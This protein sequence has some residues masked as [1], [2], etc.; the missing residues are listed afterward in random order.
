MLYLVIPQMSPEAAQSPVWQSLTTVSPSRSMLLVYTTHCTLIKY[1]VL[2]SF[3]VLQWY[4]IE[5]LDHRTHFRKII[6]SAALITSPECPHH[7]PPPPHCRQACNAAY[8]TATLIS[9]IAEIYQLLGDLPIRYL[10]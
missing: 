10:L 2:S 4:N 9:Q 5:A 6:V 1:F 7:P 3:V 8:L